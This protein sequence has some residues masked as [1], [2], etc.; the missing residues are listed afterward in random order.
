MDVN[1]KH[2]TSLLE[3]T[4]C[5]FKRLRENPDSQELTES[6]EQAKKEFDFYLHSLKDDLK[7]RYKHLP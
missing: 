1:N 7:R 6:Y 3:K 5:A 4:D 2:L